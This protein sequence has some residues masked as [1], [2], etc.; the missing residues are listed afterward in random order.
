VDQTKSENQGLLWDFTKQRE[1][2]NMD[3]D[4]S[5]R[6]RRNRQK[7]IGTGA[8]SLPNSTDFQLNAF[9]ENAHF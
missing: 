8:E 4:L 2:S 9:R 7:T 1:D 3:L 6:A 5:L